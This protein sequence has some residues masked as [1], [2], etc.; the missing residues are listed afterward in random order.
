VRGL[1]SRS[2]L[3]RGDP[4]ACERAGFLILRL[5]SVLNP[6]MTLRALNGLVYFLRRARF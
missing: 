1:V 3:L 5:V 6:A 4:L 2:L